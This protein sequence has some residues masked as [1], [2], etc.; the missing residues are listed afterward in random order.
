MSSLRKPGLGPIVGHTSDHQCHLWLRAGDPEDSGT[1]LAEGRRTIGV[2]T[3]IEK[4]GTPVNDA[5]IHYFRLHREYDRTGTFLL[6]SDTGLGETEASPELEAD[7]AYTVRLATL[8]V[9]DPFDND[10]SISDELLADRLPA[11][12]VWRELLSDSERLGGESSTARFR[13]FPDSSVTSDRIGF[14]LGSCRYPGML[15]RSKEADTIF[16]PIEQQFS[17]PKSGETAPRF[18]LMVGDQIY[19]DK[20]HR[21]VPLLRAD[22][23]AEFQERYHTALG[24]RNMSQL[25]RS[26]PHYMILDD[27]EIEDNWSADRLTTRRDLFFM[28]MYSYMSYQWCHGPRSFGTHLYY[29]FDCGSYPFFVLDTRSQRIRDDDPDSLEDNHLLGRPALDPDEPNQLGRLLHWLE[30]M[31]TTRGNTPKFIVTP[32][33]F[34]PNPMSAREEKSLFKKEQSDAWPGYPTT[35]RAI[36]DCIVDD[37]N[38]KGIQNVI[39]LAGDVHCSNVAEMHFTGTAEARE[40]KAFAITSSAFYWPFPFADGDPATLVHDSTKPGQHDTF[41]LTNGVRMDYQASN[42]VQED[43]FCRVDIDRTS[44]SITVRAYDKWG[45]LIHHE[46]RDGSQKPMLSTLEL[47]PW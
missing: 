39:F 18:V 17:A 33:V 44:H 23:L 45:E 43:N 29:H 19:A 42:F 30:T 8:T 31:Q 41:N 4:N 28:A 37:N 2:V 40:I 5:A 32:S 7:T 12:E 9:D 16:D 24:S 25:L 27:H 6:G 26:A 15:W 34:V 46:K 22:T 21:M 35:R 36:L 3:I 38:G 14:I 11:R 10:Q 20:I 1:T 47:A 13:T